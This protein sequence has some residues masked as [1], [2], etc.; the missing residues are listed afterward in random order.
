MRTIGTLRPSCLRWS[1]EISGCSFPKTEQYGR[2]MSALSLGSTHSLLIMATS[3]DSFVVQARWSRLCVR[4][5]PGPLRLRQRASPHLSSLFRRPSVLASQRALTSPRVARLLTCAGPRAP[6]WLQSAMA[7]HSQTSLQRECT[8]SALCWCGTLGLLP[9][10]AASWCARAGSPVSALGPG[11]RAM[12]CWLG[13]RRERCV[14]G[15]RARAPPCIAVLRR[16]GSRCS[17]AGPPSAVKASFVKTT[18]L[19]W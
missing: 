17:C 14:C 15:T 6:E 8:N 5:I 13:L 9:P 3:C 18:K 11:G 7:P 16:A 10:P 1:R 12:L 4:K 19:A 2:V